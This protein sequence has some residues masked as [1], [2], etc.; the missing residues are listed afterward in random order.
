MAKRPEVRVCTR[1]AEPCSTMVGCIQFLT[2]A[3]CP[4]SSFMGATGESSAH[5]TGLPAST[6]GLEATGSLSNVSRVE[7]YFRALQ[8]LITKM[9][10]CNKAVSMCEDYVENIRRKH[11]EKLVT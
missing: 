3:I 1:L 2:E 8:T 7:K 11:F 5:V 9:E 10:K 4:I 6:S